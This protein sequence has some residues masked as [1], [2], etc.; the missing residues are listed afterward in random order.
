MMGDVHYSPCSMNRVPKITSYAEAKAHYDSVKSWFHCGDKPIKGQLRYDNM[1][2][3]AYSNGAIGFR[4]YATQCVVYYPDETL[5]VQGYATMSTNAFVDTLTP[6][7]IVH[8]MGRKGWD[9]PILH[10]RRDGEGWWLDHADGSYKRNEDVLI[11]NCSDPVKLRRDEDEHRWVP[12]DETDLQ[13]FEFTE[14]DTKKARAANKQLRLQS[15]IDAAPMVDAFSPELREPDVWQFIEALET[16]NFVEALRFC[17]RGES[18]RY[19]SHEAPRPVCPKFIE[20]AR[21]IIYDEADALVK[22]KRY[23]LTLSGYEMYLRNVR[24]FET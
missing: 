19:R 12:I 11:V 8:A 24:R 10:L 7:G 15:F 2:M 4:L 6:D 1:R 3:R 5:T 23:V 9:E 13:P 14:I 16:G 22:V 18:R 20:Q 21:N 17:K